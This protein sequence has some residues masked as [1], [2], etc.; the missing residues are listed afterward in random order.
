MEDE[1]K[2]YYKYYDVK[3]D[4]EKALVDLYYIRIESRNIFIE[5]YIKKLNKTNLYGKLKE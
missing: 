2:Y 5:D 1:K 3:G 4:I